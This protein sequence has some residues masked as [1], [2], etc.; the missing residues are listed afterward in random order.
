MIAFSFFLA[1]KA[2]LFTDQILYLTSTLPGCPS[3]CLV[4]NKNMNQHMKDVFKSYERF[5]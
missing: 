2:R 4:L 1:W 5:H 3:F